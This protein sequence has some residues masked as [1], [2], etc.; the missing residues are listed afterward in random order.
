MEGK[1]RKQ[2]WAEEG[3]EWQRRH[4]E[5]SAY[6]GELW[7]IYGSHIRLGWRGLRPIHVVGYQMWA[8]W[9][10]AVVIGQTAFCSWGKS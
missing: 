9:E 7:R 10:E 1:G 3:V 6:L 2:D 5:A 8:R 4:G